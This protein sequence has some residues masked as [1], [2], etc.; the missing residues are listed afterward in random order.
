MSYKKVIEVHRGGRMESS[1]FGHAAIVNTDGDLLYSIGNPQRVTYARSSVKPIQTIPIVETGAADYYNLQDKD[2][3]LFCSSHSSEEQHTST[4]SNLL[5]RA[6]L[7]EENL[8]CGSHIPFSDDVYRSLIQQ[9]QEPTPLYSNCSGKHTGMLLTA[10][11]LG[12][13]LDDYYKQEH[14]VQQR[15]LNTMAEAAQYPKA[16]IAIGLDGC[17]VPVFGLPIDKLAHTFA[18]LARPEAFGEKRANAVAR[19]TGAMTKH[20]EMVAGTDRFCTDFMNVGSGRFFGK[21]GAES[22]YCIGDKETGL[23]I[24]VKIEDGDYKRALY[25]FVMEILVQLNILTDSQ[26]QGLDKYYQP[27]IRNARNEIIGEIIPSFVLEKSQSGF[28]SNHLS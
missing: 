17:G 24:A 14:P 9:K 3:A 27:K 1:H 7:Y 25:P 2:L 26:V 4:V 20:P 19:I 15:I 12:E 6:G 11:Y 8:Q 10:K 5:K 21:L 13:S 23:G 18:R 16:E 22:V 28:N